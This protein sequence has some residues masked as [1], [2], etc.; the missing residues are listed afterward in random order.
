[1]RKLAETMQKWM[2]LMDQEIERLENM[3]QVMMNCL[4]SAPAPTYSVKSFPINTP[5]QVVVLN[6][7][8]A[9]YQQ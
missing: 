5:G 3:V 7:L 6:E 4:K 8:Q 1:M 2:D 9:L